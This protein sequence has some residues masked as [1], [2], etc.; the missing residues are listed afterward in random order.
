MEWYPFFLLTAVS[1]AQSVAD[2]GCGG[3]VRAGPKCVYI[4]TTP[5]LSWTA[6][7]NF[8]LAKGGDLYTVRSRDDNLW[9]EMQ[10]GSGLSDYG[11]WLGL[12]VMEETFMWADGSVVNTLLL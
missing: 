1:V 6:A 3:W 2:L 9:L 4:Q 11:Y 5:T 7:R 12:R 8:C 10:A